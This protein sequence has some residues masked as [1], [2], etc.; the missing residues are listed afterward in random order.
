MITVL[1]LDD[2]QKD[3]PEIKLKH[4]HANCSGFCSIGIKLPET[5][6]EF[7]KDLLAKAREHVEANECKILMYRDERIRAE[8]IIPDRCYVISNQEVHQ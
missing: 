8:I 4:I 7:F 6:E 1:A 3:A 5:I 2:L